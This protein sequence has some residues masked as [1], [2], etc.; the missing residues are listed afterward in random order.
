MNLSQESI[1]ERTKALSY[2]AA[3]ID[4]PGS[5]K[6]V[7]IEKADIGEG[8][9]LIKLQG[10]GLCASNIPVWEG[11]EWFQY[12]LSPG[13]PGHEGWGVIENMGESVTG[14]ELG[15]RVAIIQGNAFAE[16]VKVPAIDAVFLPPELDG[17]PFPGEP[18]GCLMNIFNRADI[19]K[20]Q[21]VAIIGLGFIGLGLIKLCKEKGAK[22]VAMSR[23]ESSLSKASDDADFCLRMEDHFQIINTLQEYTQGKGCERVIECTGKQWPL[24]LA[25]AI[26][27]NYGKL[28]IAGYHQ[29]GLR[30]V[31]MQQ[32][33]W[34]AI[35]VINAHERDPDKY[36]QGIHLA[37]EAV[38]KGLLRP[39]EL[40]TNRF[41]FE[42]LREALDLL[43]ECPE[44]FVKGYVKF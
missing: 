6:Y 33:N 38:Q 37:V 1:Q 20:G 43:S 2:K 8:D 41:S 9:L 7:D 3:V 35:D 18:L 30:N 11:R 14:F 42:Q 21:T 19:Q 23:R 17:V 5:I 44:G 39:D 26:I 16:Y 28:V 4:T 15:Q 40:L 27:G 34:K 32:W 24:D 25:S 36:K 29:D 10:V 22:V 12:P 31:N 13:A